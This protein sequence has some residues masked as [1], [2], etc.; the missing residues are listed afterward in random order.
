MR[1]HPNYFV[2]RKHG[3]LCLTGEHI[4]GVGQFG[5]V[6]RG[7]LISTLKPKLLQT[8]ETRLDYEEVAVKELRNKKIARLY[9]E[10]FVEVDIAR[11]IGRHLNIVNLIGVILTGT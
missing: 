8:E 5:K 2:N 9:E 7:R 10:F 6:Y 4:V 3:C 1:K 11:K